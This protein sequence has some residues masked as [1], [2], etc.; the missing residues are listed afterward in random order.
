LHHRPVAGGLLC[1]PARQ[2]PSTGPERGP[3]RG[4]PGLR[5]GP[6]CRPL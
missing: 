1:G 4:W 5:A 6:D 3:A 2:W